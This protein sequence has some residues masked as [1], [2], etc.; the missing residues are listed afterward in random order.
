MVVL[1][2]LNKLAIVLLLK[3]FL[4]MQSLLLSN[5]FLGPLPPNVILKTDRKNDKKKFFFQMKV[6]GDTDIN[7][8][9]QIGNCLA[10]K[11]FFE[12]AI[13]LAKESFL[14]TSST[15]CDIKNGQKKMKNKIFFR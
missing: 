2:R 1:M 4:K 15:K 14:R 9:K 12:N 3:C 7:E 5:P 8:A 6:K 13:A 11:M 10:A